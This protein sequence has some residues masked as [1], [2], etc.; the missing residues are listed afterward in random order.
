MPHRLQYRAVDRCPDL[1]SSAFIEEYLKPGRPVVMR[2]FARDWPALRKWDYA[3]LKQGCGDVEVPLYSEAFANS[4]SDYMQAAQ[5]MPFGDYLDLIAAGPTPLRMFLFNVFKYMPELKND[6]SY[7]D[8]GVRFATRFPFL[9]VGGKDAYVDIHY[10]ADYSHVF[11][12]QMVGTKRIV[13]YGKEHSR[14]LYRH[15]FTVSCNIDFRDPDLERYPKLKEIE[16][17]E[18]ILEPGDT[19]FIPSG[20]W[21]FIEY[22]TAGISLS[23]RAIPDGWGQR[24]AAL[25]SLFKL[26]A[27]DHTVGKIVGSGK[28]YDLKERW[29]HA[30]ADRS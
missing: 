4:G 5:K 30:R 12:T 16:G 15:P 23:L 26:K 22:E 14:K 1:S 3:Y 2:N 11:L 25:V 20:W 24:L 9:F 19:L 29:A 10:D 7:P 13:I 21:H 6:F 27:I 28:W 18:C 17:F 8:L